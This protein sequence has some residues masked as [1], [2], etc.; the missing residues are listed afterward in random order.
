M[1][2][3]TQLYPLYEALWQHRVTV[4]GGSCPTVGI[5]G[6]TLGG[7]LGL[8]GR[9]RGLTCDNLLALEMVDAQG[10]VLCANADKNEDLYWASRGGGGGNYGVVTEF[11]FRVEAIDQVAVFNLTW[12]WE[13]LAEVLKVWQSWA[14]FTD[15]RLFILGRSGGARRKH[16]LGGS[17]PGRAAAVS[18]GWGIPQLL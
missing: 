10:Q 9:N 6:L 13:Q 11:T 15:R 12:P 4:P 16:R 3:G 2:A 1:G 7:G 5:A 8:L 18:F 14:P 17:F